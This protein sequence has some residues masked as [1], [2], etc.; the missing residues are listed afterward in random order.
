MTAETLNE[1][2]KR[3]PFVPFE[4]TMSSGQTVEIRHPEFAFILK[5]NLVVGIADSDRIAILPLLYVAGV[6]LLQAA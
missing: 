4:V 5:S 2:L 3:R 6:R 1:L